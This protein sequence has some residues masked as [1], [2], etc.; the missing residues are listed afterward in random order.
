MKH[1]FSKNLFI[2]ALIPSLII[3]WGILIWLFDLQKILVV[4]T[5]V[6]QSSLARIDPIIKEVH[7]RLVTANNLRFS[8]PLDLIFPPPLFYRSSLPRYDLTIAPK[9]TVKLEEKVQLAINSAT[10]LL[11]DE[12]N[13][14]A[15]ASLNYNGNTYQVKVKYRGDRVTHWNSHK[16]SLSIKFD[17]SSIPGQNNRLTLIIPEERNYLGAAFSKHVANKLGLM[18]QSDDFVTASINGEDLGLYYTTEQLDADFLQSRSR[19]LG[20]LYSDQYGNVPWSKQIQLFKN[21]KD[22]KKMVSYP[23]APDDTADLERLINWVQHP[24]SPPTMINEDSF[25][26]WQVHSLLLGNFTQDNTHNLKLYSNPQTQQFEFIPDDISFSSDV[27]S[28]FPYCTMFDTSYNQLVSALLI[29]PKRLQQRNQILKLYLTN[30]QNIQE[31]INYLQTQIDQL[32]A[33]FFIG[34]KKSTQLQVRY[35]MWYL[36]KGLNNWYKHLLQQLESCYESN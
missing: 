33:E 23:S 25:L 35:A 31:D 6:H 26:N 12:Y 8:R 18:V 14:W 17:N 5:W 28:F 16:K 29:D 32:S 34:E 1:N 36:P 13:I 20:N 2:S 19:P 9:E 7:A 30:P 15:P 21:I 24:I 22:W 10:G 4:R 11:T 27:S 3:W